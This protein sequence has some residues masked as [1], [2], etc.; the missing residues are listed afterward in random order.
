M[1]RVNSYSLVDN[2]NKIGDKK[3]MCPISAGGANWISGGEAAKKFRV[4][5]TRLFLPPSFQYLVPPCI[6]VMCIGLNR[7]LSAHC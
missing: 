1:V 2:V 5:R 7:V 3:V 6:R 4:L